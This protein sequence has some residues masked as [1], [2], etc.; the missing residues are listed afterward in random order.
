LETRGAQSTSSTAVDW[1]WFLAFAIASTAWCLSTARS[2]GPTYD[3][4]IYVTGGLQFWR[5]HSHALLLRLGTM[6][7]PMELDTVALAL[8][9]RGQGAVVD[10]ADD[11]G[12]VL[13][14]VRAGTLAAWWLLLFYGWRSGQQLA[15]RWGARLAVAI[16]AVEPT[17]LGHGSLATADVPVTACLVAFVYHFATRG[18]DWWQ[19]IG[20][21]GIWFWLAFM[22]KA[23]ALIFAPACMLAVEVERFVSGRDRNLVRVLLPL[24]HDAPRILM[25]GLVLAFVYC[26]SDWQSEPSFVQSAHNMSDGRLRDV[27]IWTA[28]HLRIFANAGDAIVRQFVHNLHGHHHGAFLLGATGRSFWYYFPAALSMKLSAFLLLLPIAIAIVSPSAL[29]N[30]ANFAAAALLLVS[31]TSRVQIGVRFFLPLIALAAIG[32]AASAVRAVEVS[33]NRKR[34]VLIVALAMGVVWNVIE[35]VRVWPNGL[36]YFNEFWGGTLAGYRLLSDSNYDWGQGLPE[37]ARWHAANG[38]PPLDVWYFGKDPA[39]E[40]PPFHDL[41]LH[42]LPI[43]KG[44]DVIDRVRGHYLAVSTTLLNGAMGSE[45]GERAA[46]FLRGRPAA[47]RTTTFFIYDFT[48]ET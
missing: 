15:G 43:G 32:L 3:E 8:W 35:C 39:I 12:R 22:A 41:P 31:L 34:R 16:L 19:R 11:L 7:F 6:P 13:P 17:L 2:I 38:S 28:D 29:M 44:D 5:T 14:C 36:C 40:R 45:A 24:R 26:G 46:A 10:M 9:N 30:R 21:P 47:A 42:N 4:P 27:T 23:S 48:H 25:L 33:T 18:S 37:L 1:I 20:I